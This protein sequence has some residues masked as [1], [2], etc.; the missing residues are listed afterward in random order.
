M[1]SLTIT[2]AG[3]KYWYMYRQ[4]HRTNG[5]A[6][7]LDDGTIQWFL[8]GRFHRA[9]GPAISYSDGYQAWFIYG[10]LVDEFSHLFLANSKD[11]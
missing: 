3:G 9:N 10:T 4:L 6:V 7:E 2:S 11:D 1:I 8:Y 5:P